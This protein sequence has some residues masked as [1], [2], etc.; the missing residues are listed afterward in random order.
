MI[1]STLMHSWIVLVGNAAVLAIIVIAFCLIVGAIKPGEVLKH[2]GTLVCV[3][4]LLIILPAIIVN[5]W[6]AM[7]ILR[8]LCLIAVLIIIAFAF[9]GVLKAKPRRKRR[10]GGGTYRHD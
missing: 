7:S 2:V 10:P 6:A 5:S 4:I 3:L 9:Q 8:R 1:L